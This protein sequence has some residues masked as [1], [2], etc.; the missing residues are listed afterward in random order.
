MRFTCIKPACGKSYTSDEPEAYYCPSCIEE[1]KAIAAQIDAQMA[2]KMRSPV[3]SELQQFERDAKTFTD[4][5]T[6]RT[7][8]FGRA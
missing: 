3:V 1:K 8:T 4:P 6:G 2:T 7:I 5:A